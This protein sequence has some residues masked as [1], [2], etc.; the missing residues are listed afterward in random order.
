MTQ[1]KTRAGET[2]T[3]R[4]IGREREKENESTNEAYFPGYNFHIHHKYYT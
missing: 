3:E 4:E 2:H 1:A